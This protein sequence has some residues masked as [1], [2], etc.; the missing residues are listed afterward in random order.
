MFEKGEYVVYGSKGV[1][2]VKDISHV[3]IPGADSERLYY[4][5]YPVQ[6]NGGTVYLPTDSQKAVIRRVMTREEA[7]QLIADI[8]EIEQL[9]VSNDK[10]REAEYK[11]AM[12]SCN[13]RAWVSILKALHLRKKERTEAGKKVTALDERYMRA[14]ENELYGELSVALG[15]PQEDMETYIH[16]KIGAEA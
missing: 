14:A 2:Q 11:N 12:R 8:P 5:L 13:T 7:D 1:C 10:N 16:G 4:I 6:S 15:I 3:D 9:P